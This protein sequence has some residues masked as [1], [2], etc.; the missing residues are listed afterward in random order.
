MIMLLLHYF[1]FSI[2][3]NTCLTLGNLEYIK[4]YTQE[5]NTHLYFWYLEL[6]IN[7]FT[8]HLLRK[9]TAF[10]KSNTCLLQRICII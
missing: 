8:P 5:N 6:I 7:L 9:I 1:H 10:Y 2:T 4:W 3:I